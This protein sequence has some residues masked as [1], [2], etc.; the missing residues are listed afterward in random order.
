MNTP[1][2]KTEMMIHL[3]LAVLSLLSNANKNEIHFCIA[4]E[5]DKRFLI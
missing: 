5:D 3:L 2:L 1:E 4:P